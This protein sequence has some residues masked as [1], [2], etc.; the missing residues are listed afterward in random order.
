MIENIFLTYANNSLR[1]NPEIFY[2][3]IEYFKTLEFIQITNKVVSS[4]TGEI[5]EKG[6]LTGIIKYF[7]ELVKCDDLQ[8]A[9]KIRETTKFLENEKFIDDEFFQIAYQAV[10][11]YSDGYCEDEDGCYYS[12]VRHNILGFNKFD[13]T[14][15][16]K[17]Y[18][19]DQLFFKYML[20]GI[21]KGKEYS[22]IG[23]GLL[24]T[25][26]INANKQF[27][28]H[29]NIVSSSSNSPFKETLQ[30]SVVYMPGVYTGENYKASF[31]STF[32]GDIIGYSL[33]EF[34]LKNDRRKLKQCPHCQ[35]F[36]IAKDI[37]RKRCYSDEC[38]KAYEREK[39]QKQR[40]KDPVKY[41]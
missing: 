27:K 8:K 9:I 39:K 2:E 37:K 26:L 31:S 14:D 29:V 33:T 22:D 24:G 41:C 34:L 4:V 12:N 36:F 20:N 6:L 17:C 35:K 10:F 1:D 3:I 18:E 7:V 13:G 28:K 25:F 16:I 19:C 32:L 5:S 40:E 15:R 11:G 21:V 30:E 38:R 23:L